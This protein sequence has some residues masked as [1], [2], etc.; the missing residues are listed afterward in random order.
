MIDRQWSE[1]TTEE[2]YVADLQRIVEDADTQLLIYDRGQGPVAAA[3]G[4]NR[5]PVRRLEAMAQPYL[6]IAYS[7]DRGSI[8]TGYQ[9]SQ[10]SQVNVT[11][12][13]LWLT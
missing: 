6:F 12:K 2:E 13:P 5:I 1:G 11:E 7:A 9:V 10:L 3:I 4:P 8:I